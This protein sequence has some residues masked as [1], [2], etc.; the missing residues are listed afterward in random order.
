MK[1]QRPDRR[2]KIK[3]RRG[4]GGS[5]KRFALLPLQILLHP[6][7]VTL[8]NAQ[9]RV[10]VAIAAQYNSHNNGGLAMTRAMAKEF[11][12]NSPDTLHR[13]LSEIERRGLIDRTW[14][15]SRTPPT[16]ARFSINWQP[17]NKTEWTEE[18]GVSRRYTKWSQES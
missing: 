15:G 7:V 1:H 16:A 9:F 6:A 13:S 4:D 2:L 14:P 11:G 17:L 3:G 12:I 5:S 18:G 8:T 10:L